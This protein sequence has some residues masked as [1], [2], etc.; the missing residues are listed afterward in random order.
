MLFLPG[1]IVRKILCRGPKSKFNKPFAKSAL[2]HK[3]KIVFV[4]DVKRDPFI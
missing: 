4:L 1:K 2:I 3:K